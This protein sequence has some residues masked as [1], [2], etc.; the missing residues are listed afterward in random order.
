MQANA[1][2]IGAKREVAKLKRARHI[3]VLF[4]CR[5]RGAH[6]KAASVEN[7]SRFTVITYI[8]QAS[9]HTTQ[10]PKKLDNYSPQQRERK[11]KIFSNIITMQL[12][13]ETQPLNY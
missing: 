7:F 13:R 1:M 5:A 6:N 9:A 10:F 3:V 4:T 12:L 11:K 2:Q 8:S